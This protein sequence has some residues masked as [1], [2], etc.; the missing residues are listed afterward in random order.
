MNA[1]LA[2]ISLIL[3]LLCLNVFQ[4]RAKEYTITDFGAIADSSVTSTK[5]IQQAIDQCSLTGGTVIIPA[6]NFCTGSLVLKSN[7]NL[8]LERGATLLGSRNYD[9][10]IPNTP[11]YVAL[12]TRG[13]AKQLIYAEDARN[14]AITGYGE[15]NGQGRFFPDRQAKG[16]Q[17]DRP[18][19]IQFIN[20]SR[21]L[22][23]NVSLRNSGCWMQHYLACDFLQIRSIKV[24]NHSNKNNDGIDV[25]G[26]RNVTI[27]DAIVDSDDDAICIKSTSARASENISVTNCVLS[28]H[29]NAFKLGTESNTGFRNIVASNLII[30]PS[31]VSDKQIYGRTFG[32]SGISLEMVDG[33]N[34]DGVAISNVV[35]DGAA[36]PIFIR[37]GNRNRPYTENQVVSQTGTLKNI[38]LSHIVATNAKKIGCSITGIPG[39]Q[40]E[41][42]RLN[43]VHI[44]FEGGGTGEDY[45]RIIPEE[46]KEYPEAAMFGIL[47]SYGFFIRHASNIKFTEVSVKTASPDARPALILS[48]VNDSEFSRMKLGSTKGNECAINISNS[49][50][51]LISES[52]VSGEANSFLKI[53]GPLSKRLVIQ[54]NILENTKKLFDS[55]N[56]KSAV[57][58]SG[59]LIFDGIKNK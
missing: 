51:L 14:I 36:V 27:S 49:S 9:D 8:H 59:N 58:E 44:E 52:K 26:C 29:C 13:K 40:V 28:S 39:H 38:S 50:N 3:F 21:V 16:V 23:E 18:H 25:D 35:I 24:F 43:D 42:I 46:E 34:L 17:Y 15:I 7:V 19:L 41:N 22:I 30:K 32:I 47:S 11:K 6:G 48:D 12:R 5:A 56:Q 57:V 2:K 31:E 37:L 10:Y 53:D 45:S 54:N 33:G 4:G 20:C 55:G 1:S